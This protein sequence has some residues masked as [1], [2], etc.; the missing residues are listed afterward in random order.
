[1]SIK[2]QGDIVI[3]NQYDLYLRDG[4]FTRHVE[5]G[6]NLDMDDGHIKNVREIELK[7]WDSNAG[8]DDD[9]VRL[10]RRYYNWMLYNG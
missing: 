8:G 4:W 6:G 9:S 7:D 2:I 3:S 5:I 10:L 1:M